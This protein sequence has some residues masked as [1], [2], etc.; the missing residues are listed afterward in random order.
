VKPVAVLA[1][2]AADI[3][4]AW[5]FYERQDVGLGGYFV[6]SI[7]QDLRRLEVLHGTHPMHQVLVWPGGTGVPPNTVALA[8]KI[9]PQM[10]ADFRRYNL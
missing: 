7:L 8:E 10:A 5:S 3:E 4:A 2:A 9:D 6:R 1:E